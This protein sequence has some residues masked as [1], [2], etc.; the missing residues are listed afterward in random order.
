MK[1]QSFLEDLMK[2]PIPWMMCEKQPGVSHCEEKGK[3][4]P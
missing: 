3:S 4:P 1:F 2:A